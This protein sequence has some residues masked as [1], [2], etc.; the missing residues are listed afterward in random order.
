MHMNFASKGHITSYSRFYALKLSSQPTALNIKL[1][2][3]A[4][5]ELCMA[6]N[7]STLKKM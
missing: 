3:V 6:S 1:V 7:M 4:H 2:T 5:F